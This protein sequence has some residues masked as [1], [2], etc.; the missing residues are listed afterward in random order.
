MPTSTVAFSPGPPPD[1]DITHCPGVLHIVHVPPDD[2]AFA[3]AMPNGKW[4]RLTV[5]AHEL[6]AVLDTV[7]EKLVEAMADQH[8]PEMPPAEPE[9]AAPIEEVPTN[10]PP[11]EEQPNE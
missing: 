8:E 9:P 11:A 10:A 3:V 5:D 7:H 1:A 2:I 4:A 6:E